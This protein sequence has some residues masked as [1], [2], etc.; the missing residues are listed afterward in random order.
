MDW[1][2]D[3]AGSEQVVRYLHQVYGFEKVYTL[4]DVMSQA[5]KEKIF[6]DKIPSIVSSSLQHIGHKFRYALPL[7][8]LALKSI[9][10][11]EEN[12]LIISVTHSVIKGIEFPKGSVHT[13]YF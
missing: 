1:L 7:F 9:K 3:Y 10:V 4:V 2:D 6:G 13:S 12:A 5:H 11:Q 8:P